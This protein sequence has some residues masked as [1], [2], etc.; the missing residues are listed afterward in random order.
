MFVIKLSGLL[1]AL[2]ASFLLSL[3]ELSASPIELKP[4]G[5]VFFLRM[6]SS[7]FTL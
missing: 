5:S 6:S 4:E 1:Q 7:F 3:V 2:G